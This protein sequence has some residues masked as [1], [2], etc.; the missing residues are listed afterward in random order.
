MEAARSP[1]GDSD[2]GAPPQ[3]FQMRPPCSPWRGS[4]VASC[5]L[6]P[7]RAPSMMA[8]ATG[9][10]RGREKRMIVN[11]AGFVTLAALIVGLF[12]WLRTDVADVKADVKD[13]RAGMQ[14]LRAEVKADVKD[15][16]ADVKELRADMAELR[17][18][19]ARLEGTMDGLRAAVAGERRQPAA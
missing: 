3:N 18:R 13:L 1:P 10:A 14:D 5:R 6:R 9:K 16:R 7:N 4:P 17:E 2:V 15:L 11:I 12:G 19:M 8:L